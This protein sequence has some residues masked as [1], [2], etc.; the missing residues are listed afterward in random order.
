MRLNGR[1]DVLHVQTYLVDGEVPFLCGKQ[2]LES[3]NFK[4]DSREIILEIHVNNQQD[5]DRKQLKMTDTKGG[6]YG[7]ILET[8]KNQNTAMFLVENY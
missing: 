2:T 1:E 3:W 5:T 8:R 7:I 4:I 6:H